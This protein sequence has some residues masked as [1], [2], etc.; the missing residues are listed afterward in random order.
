[1]EVVSFLVTGPL[2]CNC[3][4]YYFMT[5]VQCKSVKWKVNTVCPPFVEK[6]E[7]TRKRSRLAIIHR[8]TNAMATR[9][10]VFNHDLMQYIYRC[11]GPAFICI[12]QSMESRAISQRVFHTKVHEA[13][14]GG[15]K[16]GHRTQ[17]YRRLHKISIQSRFSFGNAWFIHMH[18]N[19]Q[20]QESRHVCIGPAV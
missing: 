13:H 4:M 17:E 9:W 11:C 5:H 10:W 2:R 20:L 15:L 18:S 14:D 12:F 19:D 3:I 6:L 16:V 7:W 8:V 1:M